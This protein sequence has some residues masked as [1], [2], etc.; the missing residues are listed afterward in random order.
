VGRTHD[1]GYAEY[2]SV[3][4][5]QVIPV[6]TDLPWE[7]L[8]ALPEMVQIAYGSLTIGLRLGLTPRQRADINRRELSSVSPMTSGCR[9]PFVD[10]HG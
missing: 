5:S 4:L 1:G 10:V 8:G 9:R 3:P 7:M 6:D 2:T